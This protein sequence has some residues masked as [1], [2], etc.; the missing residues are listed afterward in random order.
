MGK[1]IRPARFRR[2]KSI[3]PFSATADERDPD[4]ELWPIGALL[5]VASVARVVQAIGSHE[6]FGA[7]PTFALLFALGLPW[8]VFHSRRKPG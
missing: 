7:E 4:L 3:A 5:F 6:R 2:D 8:L 1:L